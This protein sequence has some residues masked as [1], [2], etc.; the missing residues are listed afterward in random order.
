MTKHNTMRL[1]KPPFSHQHGYIFDD[2]GQMVADTPDDDDD[3]GVIRIRGWGRL[4]NQFGAEK[5]AQVQD[6]IAELVV[7]AMN[8]FWARESAE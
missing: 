3:G 6:E 7:E 8:A 1:L 4:R 2:A 5:A